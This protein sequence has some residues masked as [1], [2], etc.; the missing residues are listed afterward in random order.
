MSGREIHSNDAAAGGWHYHGTT[1][2]AFA[3][4]PGPGQE[5]IWDYPRP[6]ICVSQTRH[7]TVHRG[8]QLI[9]DTRAS[10]R[11]LETAGAPTFY[12]PPG[13]IDFGLLAASD[14]ESFCEWKGIARYWHVGTGTARIDNAAW[15]YPDIPTDS[16]YA[17]ISGYLSFYAQTLDCRVDGERARSQPGGFYGGWITDDV[18]G[19]FKGEPGTSGW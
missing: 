7:V 11:M 12:I 2:P 15:C 13:D 17:L 16:R 8:D 10:V 5:S 19:P 1:R 6:P 3:R 18:V 14:R 9:A 4:T